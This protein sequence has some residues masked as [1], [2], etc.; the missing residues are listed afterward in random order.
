MEGADVEEGGSGILEAAPPALWQPVSR[1]SP[2][3]LVDWWSV[4]E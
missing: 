1:W 4:M 2:G 3:G